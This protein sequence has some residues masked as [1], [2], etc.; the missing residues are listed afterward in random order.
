MPNL[1]KNNYN[2]VKD[3]IEFDDFRNNGKEKTLSGYFSE[4]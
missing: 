1:T 2:S 4:L 3:K